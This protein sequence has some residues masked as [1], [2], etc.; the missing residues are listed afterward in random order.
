MPF[1]VILLSDHGYVSELL[2]HHLNAHYGVTMIAIHRTSYN[3]EYPS[4]ATARMI[5]LQAH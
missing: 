5:A 2:R 1:G 3:A 4:G